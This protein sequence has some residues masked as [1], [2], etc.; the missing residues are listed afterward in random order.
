VRSVYERI[1]LRITKERL[2]TAG[3]SRD[4]PFVARDSFGS[5]SYSLGNT[6]Q[7]SRRSAASAG[8]G[9]NPSSAGCSAFV[10]RSRPF[11]RIE[12]LFLRFPAFLRIWD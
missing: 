6:A 9:S 1:T 12:R 8:L 2:A 4:A 11:S 10:L 3:F 7:L 5:L